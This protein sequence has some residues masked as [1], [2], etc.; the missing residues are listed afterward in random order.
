MSLTTSRMRESDIN[1]ILKI[2]AANQRENL[3]P[4]Q[5]KDG[6]L[7]IAFSADEFNEFN[8]DLCVVVAKEDNEVIGYCC[9]SSA[10][11]NSQFPILDQIVANVASYPLPETDDIPVEERTCI[12]GPVCVSRSRRGKGVLKKISSFGLEIA[13]EIGYTYCLSFISA[14]NVRSISAHM[15]ISFQQVGKVNHNGNEYIVIATK[16]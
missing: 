4:S 3:T 11:F 10:G 9:I 12:Y 5:Q 2:Q 13:K 6:Y 14:E 7:S 15:K 8:H 16:L 1:Q